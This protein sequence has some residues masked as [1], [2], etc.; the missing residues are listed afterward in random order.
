M[1]GQHLEPDEQTRLAPIRWR[2]WEILL[3][4]TDNNGFLPR[5][6]ACHRAAACVD[7]LRLPE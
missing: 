1:A 4:Q 7:L 2:L 3:S 5:R 6:E